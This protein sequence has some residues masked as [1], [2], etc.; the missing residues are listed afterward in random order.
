MKKF[1]AL[2][3][4]VSGLLLVACGESPA[5]TPTATPAQAT[6]TETA[7]RGTYHTAHSGPYASANSNHS[8]TG[9][10]TWDTD[11]WG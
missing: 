10:H 8:S 5:A 4:L 7:Y 1:L 6:P 9:R 3:F 11:D 2:L